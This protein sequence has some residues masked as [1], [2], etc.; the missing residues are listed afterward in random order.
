MDSAPPV[1][2]NTTVNH[3][4]HSLLWFLSHHHKAPRPLHEFLIRASKVTSHKASYLLEDLIQFVKEQY[5]LLD[6]V[7]DRFVKDGVQGQ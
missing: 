5:V 6:V 3:L 7:T 2:V 4:P 1:L